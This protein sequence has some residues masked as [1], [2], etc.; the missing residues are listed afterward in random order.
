MRRPGRATGAA[1]RGAKERKEPCGRRGSAGAHALQCAE[2]SLRCREPKET[3]DAL[4][5]AAKLQR[6]P[7]TAQAGRGIAGLAAPFPVS[8]R[9]GLG[10]PRGGNGDRD[11][12][13][14]RLPATAPLKPHFAMLSP[15]QS[16]RSLWV[17]LAEA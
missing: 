17:R 5:L 12:H 16:I 8:S 1:R 4:Q 15:V 7:P 10:G 6:R 13:G 11:G 3:F 9:V 14:P 2:G